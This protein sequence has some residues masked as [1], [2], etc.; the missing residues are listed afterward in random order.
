[1]VIFFIP[2]VMDECDIF[3]NIHILVTLANYFKEFPTKYLLKS[4]KEN[5]NLGQ[6][7]YFLLYP[8]WG[9]YILHWLYL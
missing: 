5:N 1:M 3:D 6:Q 8:S 7:I 9:N 4:Y 2:C